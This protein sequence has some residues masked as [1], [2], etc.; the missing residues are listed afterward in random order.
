MKSAYSAPEREWQYKCPTMCKFL[1][2]KTY[3]IHNMFPSKYWFG[4]NWFAVAHNRYISVFCMYCPRVDYK[5]IWW[6]ELRANPGTWLVILSGLIGVVD[7]YQRSLISCYLL[8]INTPLTPVLHGSYEGEIDSPLTFIDTWDNHL[9]SWVSSLVTL[10]IIQLRILNSSLY[11][12]SVFLKVFRMD[13]ISS[14]ILKSVLLQLS[15]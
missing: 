13:Q 11:S 2:S 9:N 6:Q 7:V 3:R 8:V 5:S 12:V 14:D 15:F 1:L 4:L 10:D